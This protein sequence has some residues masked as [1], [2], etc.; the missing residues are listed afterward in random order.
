MCLA[1][2]EF[3][4]FLACEWRGWWQV[5]STDVPDNLEEAAVG[6]PPERLIG[7]ALDRFFITV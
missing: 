6:H 2:Y 1:T 7:D 5:D 3:G 4:C